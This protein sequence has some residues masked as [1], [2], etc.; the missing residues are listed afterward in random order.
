LAETRVRKRLRKSLWSEEEVIFYEWC[1]R[2]SP[3]EK[4]NQPRT[5]DANQL[6]AAA[7]QNEND[8][9][10]LAY[11]LRCASRLQAGNAEGFALADPDGRFL[12]FGW[13]TAFDGFFLSELNA[14][15]DAPSL[16]S[17][18]LFDCW[19]PIALRG[20][21]YFAKT[22]SLIAERVQEEGKAP[23]TFSLASSFPSTRGLEKS[24]FQRR[25]SLIRQHTLLWQRIKGTAPGRVEA[26]R[27]EASAR[28]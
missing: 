5:L 15:L 4:V 10:T 20:H 16:N 27:P 26:P 12:H 21:G 24:G 25:Y 17:A 18:M 14:K 23:W 7:M 6:A 8:R 3:V 28:V 1:G 9:E 2:V 11:L 22:V 19:T 13:V